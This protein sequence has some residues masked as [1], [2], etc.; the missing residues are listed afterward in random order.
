MLPSGQVVI[1]F[2]FLQDSPVR[3]TAAFFPTLGSEPQSSRCANETNSGRSS[4]AAALPWAPSA[5]VGD[6]QSFR[7]AIIRIIPHFRITAAAF[8]GYSS[9]LRIGARQQ[10]AARL[11]PFRRITG[12]LDGR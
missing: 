4:G 10:G 2:S 11:T 12:Q 5:P 7:P 8:H 3:N 1:P 6:D 9:V